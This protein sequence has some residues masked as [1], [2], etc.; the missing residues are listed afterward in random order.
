MPLFSYFYADETATG[1]GEVPVIKLIAVLRR[2]IARPFSM[3]VADGVLSSCGGDT[4][5][6]PWKTA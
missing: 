6:P 4:W 3:D 2:G 5:R 1:Q